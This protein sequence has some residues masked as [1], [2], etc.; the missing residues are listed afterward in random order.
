M[1]TKRQVSVSNENLLVPSL[2]SLLSI[3]TWYHYM[4]DKEWR[5][6]RFNSDFKLTANFSPIF[7]H[8]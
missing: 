7:G 6:N 1:L 2:F 8:E 5:E 4:L 3:L